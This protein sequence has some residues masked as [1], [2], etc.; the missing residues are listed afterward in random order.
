MNK[1]KLAITL[2]DATGIGPELIAKV[3]SDPD[4]KQYADYIVIGDQRTLEMGIHIAKVELDYKA[5]T[6]VEEALDAIA[7]GIHPIIDQ[8]NLDINEFKLG[9]VSVK[10]GKVTGDDLRYAIELAKSRVVDG[11]VYAPLNKE[12]M[13][14]GGHHFQDETEYFAH[15]LQFD[16]N[17]GEMNTIN[18]LWVARVTSHI[19]LKDVPKNITKENVRKAINLCNK[20]LTEAG[21]EKPSIGVG[22]LNPHAG[23]GGLFGD[24]EINIIG[25]AIEEAK[26]D[27]INVKGPYPP[28]TMFITALDGEMDAIIGMYHDQAQIGFKMAGF[29]R[30]V[31]INAG[32]PVIL[33]TPSHGTAFDIVGT[34]TANPAPMKQ[35]IIIAANTATSRQKRNSITP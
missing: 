22:G 33:T 6:N 19:A 30:G 29:K 14:K 8:R 7:S 3:L 28:D 34:G 32:L 11:V 2:G 15:L 13:H 20:T 16:G 25:P 21:F 10:S 35:S 12:A 23:E 26:K 9:E 18:N 31:S 27:G 4:L 17:Y 1:P 24:E 5:V